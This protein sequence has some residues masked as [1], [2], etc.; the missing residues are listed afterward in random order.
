MNKGDE[1]KHGI[2]LGEVIIDREKILTNDEFGDLPA[3]YDERTPESSP[4]VFRE[5][6]IGYVFEKDGKEVVVLIE[7]FKE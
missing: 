6:A 2:Y 5:R 7:D 1:T 3:I 4:D